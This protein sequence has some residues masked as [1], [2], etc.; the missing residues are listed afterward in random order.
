M[1][2]AQS[3]LTTLGYNLVAWPKAG[4]QP[5]TLLYKTDNGVSSVEAMLK[6]LFKTG[7][8]APP[9]VKRNVDATDII[10]TATLSFDAQ[11]GVKMLDWLLNKL[12]LGKMSADVKLN[13]SYEVD[14][15]YV[16]IKED[17]VNLLTLDGFL[18]KS[19]PSSE[20]FNTFKEKLEN[21]ELYV[22]TAVAKSCDISVTISAKNG[23]D[24]SADVNIKGIL[25]SNISAAR[26]QGKSLELVYKT[27]DD[28]PVIFAFKAQQIIYEKKSFWS[29]Q[30]AR[31]YIKD[32]VGAVLLG[33]EDIPTH[34]L[35]TGEELIEL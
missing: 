31:F 7:E 29:G 13:D 3:P 5:L 22:I 30:P 23:Q 15:S 17:K 33:P 4:I 34:A 32:Q 1:S 11:G 24:V 19:K 21:N 35:Q 26:K 8:T 14:V 12:H 28:M 25:E 20:K 27:E 16:K 6:D 9:Q 18:S 2:T 10:G